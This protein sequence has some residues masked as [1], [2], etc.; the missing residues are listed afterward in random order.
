MLPHL[1]FTISNNTLR[2]RL[3]ELVDMRIVEKRSN[4][5]KWLL[6]A[7]NKQRYHW[8][9]I[10]TVCDNNRDNLLN[11]ALIEQQVQDVINELLPARISFLDIEQTSKD[12][13]AQLSKNLSSKL[14][15]YIKVIMKLVDK[16]LFSPSHG[17]SVLQVNSYATKYWLPQSWT[18]LR[19]PL[20]R[21]KNSTIEDI[22]HEIE[23]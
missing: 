19:I 12:I 15:F 13:L 9:A 18:A 7:Y 22:M 14:D 23:Q 1:S 6:D 21:K 16:G 4:N 5:W 10:R 2:S 11:H 17:Y 20:L 3:K 8:G